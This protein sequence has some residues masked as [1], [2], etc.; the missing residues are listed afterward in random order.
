[1]SLSGGTGTLLAMLD[2]Q[3]ASP[4][5]LLLRLNLSCS[6]QASSEKVV[7]D[8]LYSSASQERDDY[9]Y[10]HACWKRNYH[11]SIF[12]QTRCVHSS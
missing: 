1:M 12:A 9:R 5:T 3:E 6:Y 8:R 11:A 10:L 4:L 2:L 7:Y